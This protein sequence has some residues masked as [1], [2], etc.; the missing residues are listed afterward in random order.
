MTQKDNIWQE[1]RE[2]KSSLD[3]IT[4]Q[5]VYTVPAGYF[6][7]LVPQILNRIKALE[8]ATG[9]EELCY[10]SSVLATCS[11]EIPYTVPAGYF[12]TLATQVLR[13]IK[14]IEAQS[15]EEELEYLSPILSG[16]S[17]QMPYTVPT[18]YFEEL[19]EKA[20]DNTAG[21]SNLSAVEELETLSP[22]LGGLKKEMPYT[23]PQGYFDNLING[24]NKEANKPAAKVVSIAGRKWFRYAAA[25]VM[26]GVIATIGLKFIGQ[27]KN[28]S[29][30]KDPHAWVEKGIKKVS[31]DN[32]NEFI[33]LSDAEK[34]I[35]SADP[36]QQQEIKEL[37]KDVPDNEIQSL[38]N[39]T[40]ILDDGTDDAAD[41]TLMN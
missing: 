16:L 33:Q 4:R 39:D 22:F 6:E 12:E 17:R 30:N 25:A 20:I 9:T 41:G 18:G 34:S 31:T 21:D 7:G 19:N 14:A 15:P 40:Q 1:L 37:I 24:I 2:L 32:L 29:I 23:V 5:N 36:K 10:L 35:V 38:I 26:T 28:V 3:E 11:K 13:R 27:N 8:A